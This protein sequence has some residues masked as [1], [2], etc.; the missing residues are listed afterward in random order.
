MPGLRS[1][2]PRL[3]VL[4]SERRCNLDPRRLWR[5]SAPAGSNRGG[6]CHEGASGRGDCRPRGGDCASD[7]GRHQGGHSP[8]SARNACRRAGHAGRCDTN[9][10]R[11][12]AGHRGY[13]LA[14]VATPSLP[15]ATPIATVATWSPRRHR[16]GRRPGPPRPQQ[17]LQRHLP[18]REPPRPQLHLCRRHNTP[19]PSL[20]L[21]RPLPKPNAQHPRPQLRAP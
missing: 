11:S 10:L 2:R 16:P 17:V 7:P 6:C 21:L 13:A 18:P 3:P 19:L 5:T 12:D 20:P 14:E 1:T 8:G 4:A 9:F 15:R